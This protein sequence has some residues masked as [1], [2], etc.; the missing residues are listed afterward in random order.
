MLNSFMCLFVANF[1]FVLLVSLRERGRVLLVHVPFRF[2]NL[3]ETARAVSVTQ[4]LRLLV[5][6]HH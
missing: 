2:F 6:Q 4:A 5:L 1:F 3:G